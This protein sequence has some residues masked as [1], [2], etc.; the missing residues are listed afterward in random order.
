MNLVRTIEME[1]ILKPTIIPLLLIQ[2]SL[3]LGLRL[4]PPRKI[5]IIKE[6]FEKTIQLLESILQIVKKD[7]NKDNGK[8]LSHI[9]CYTCK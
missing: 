4:K 9:K 1:T 2:V 7:K 5:N 8:D 6:V 3:R